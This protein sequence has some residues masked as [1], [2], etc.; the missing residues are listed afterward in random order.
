MPSTDVSVIIISYKTRDLT[1]ACLTSVYRETRGVSFEVIVVDNASG[2]GSAEMVESCFPEVRLIS[3][4][5]NLGFGP[6]NNLAAERANG[7]YLLLLNPDTIVK[8][9]ALK[10][11]FE[12]AEANPEAGAWG[13]VCE[14]PNGQIDPGCR[15]IMPS[16]WTLF[17]SFFV[18]YRRIADRMDRG[19]DF[20]GDVSV[21]S[22]AFMMV[23]SD[24]WRELG[25][26][27]ESFKLYAEEC[28]LCDRILK[29]KYRIMMT[30]KSR[31][32]HYSGA[33]E[34]D[35]SRSETN[36]TRGV[37]HFFR[38][39]YSIGGATAGGILI[40]LY[41]IERLIVAGL[42][43]P[44]IGTMRCRAICHRLSSIAFR[45]S[46]WWYGWKDQRL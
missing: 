16:L 8:D 44:F 2:D 27:D 45:P 15:Q 11:L 43:I 37:M 38:K 19:K 39:H 14:L 21:L 32:V 12:F 34:P 23:R 20:Q 40:W 33:G 46:L 25:G 6:G 31:I 22:G 41:S 29:A 4:E 24:V 42:S 7:R 28:D 3:S 17:S 30:G 10:A 9:N 18:R 1:Q 35:D 5:G 36:Q 13:G 26:F